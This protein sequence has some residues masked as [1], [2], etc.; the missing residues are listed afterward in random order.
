M[1]GDTGPGRH[2]QAIHEAAVLAETAGSGGRVGS[3][4]YPSQ[5]GPVGMGSTCGVAVGQRRAIASRVGRGASSE[6]KSRP[7]GRWLAG[8]VRVG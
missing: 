1:L 2:S 8:E 4:F 5:P 7:A 3:S 6:A